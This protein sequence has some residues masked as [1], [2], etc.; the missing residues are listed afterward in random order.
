MRKEVKVKKEAL[1]AVL[2]I[3]VDG[4]NMY[5]PRTWNEAREIFNYFAREGYE[6]AIHL[7]KPSSIPEDEWESLIDALSYIYML[8][9]DYVMLYHSAYWM[10]SLLR[11]YDWSGMKENINILKSF[12]SDYIEEKET[13]EPLDYKLDKDC[14]NGDDIVA[15]AHVIHVKTPYEYNVELFI[16]NV[17]EDV[18][19]GEIK[20]LLEEA[21]YYFGEF[22]R[23]SNYTVVKGLSEMNRQMRHQF[24]EK[25]AEFITFKELLERAG[26]TE[27]ELYE[28]KRVKKERLQKWFNLLQLEDEE[29]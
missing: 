27:E 12:L 10:G 3:E 22:G 18:D 6:P 15:V 23:W 25:E 19:T 5:S 1:S 28:E 11:N 21:G 7:N 17:P 20:E 14:D 24:H 8:E 4:G 16:S 26:R 29:A 9:D 13:S 2:A